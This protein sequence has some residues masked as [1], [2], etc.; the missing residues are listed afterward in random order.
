MQPLSNATSSGVTLSF[1][2]INLTVSVHSAI[3]EDVTR[4]MRIVCNHH[5]APEITQARLASEG[6]TLTPVKQHMTCPDCEA[7]GEFGKAVKAGDGLVEITDE[8]LAED[9]SAAEKLKKQI[10]MTV[11]PR[12]QVTASMMPSGKA[13]YLNI[14]N[15]AKGT[16]DAY[17]MLSQLIASR[18]NLAFMTKFALR[19]AVS[20]FMLE[21]AG[22]GTLVLRQMADADLVRQHPAITFT[23]L[24]ERTVELAGLVCDA[25]VS[26]FVVA[27]HGSGKSNV[28]A[29]YAATQTPVVVAP[30]GAPLNPAASNVLDLTAQLEAM[31]AASAA[32]PVPDNATVAKVT[33]VRKPRKTAAKKATTA[34]KVG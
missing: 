6:R 2:L 16:S 11:H 13:Y 24:D 30:A 4:Q 29:A 28:I 3:G 27:E 15:P 26:D 19:S 12:E 22:E 17:T 23:E 33:P 14:K 9:R 8:V 18:P 1:G 34:R 7:T 32:N 20:V 5:T 31:M 25:Q 10:T 21:V